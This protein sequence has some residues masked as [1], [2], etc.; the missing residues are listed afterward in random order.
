MRSEPP[1]L[2]SDPY[3]WHSF[4][5]ED[6]HD[7]L[8]ALG[9]EWGPAAGLPWGAPVPLLLLVAACTLLHRY[10]PEDG[11]VKVAVSFGWYLLQ[12]ADRE[13]QVAQER[14]PSVT[15]GASFG[16]NSIV[17]PAEYLSDVSEEDSGLDENTAEEEKI[18]ISLLDNKTFERDSDFDLVASP[19][20]GSAYRA[21]EISSLGHKRLWEEA[22]SKPVSWH[23]NSTFDSDSE[24]ENASDK[25]EE[26]AEME[27]EVKEEEE[28]EE[29]EEKEEEE[30]EDVDNMVTIGVCFDC[31]A[32]VKQED[33]SE[34]GSA[35]SEGQE[36]Q[37]V[38]PVN[39]G[40][41]PS[42]LDLV[43]QT[44]ARLFEAAGRETE[45]PPP[46]PV[47]LDLPPVALS[48]KYMSKGYKQGK[49]GAEVA[50]DVP[51]ADLAMVYS[52]RTDGHLSATWRYD[53]S[54]YS[55]DSIVRM[56]ANFQHL[57]IEVTGNS[58]TFR[59]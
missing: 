50:Q 46:P 29:E 10:H 23:I 14:P 34:R 30:E 42:L 45:P 40:S 55:K 33:G 49:G 5:L 41:K 28:E 51:P 7:D 24:S 11:A 20:P 19:G 54:R 59:D 48:F 22:A 8:D 1:T 3:E 12:S 31:E 43:M 9:C 6:A 57:L 38:Y 56:A 37:S 36:A 32:G 58:E 21:G 26:E 18:S 47:Q 13:A 17:G 4:L 15:A 25:R 35:Y 39:T 44:S 53:T 52:V 27:V 16:A 2:Q